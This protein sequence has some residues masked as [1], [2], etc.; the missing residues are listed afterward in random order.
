MFTF[1]TVI[2]SIQNVKKQM[3]NTFVTDT[4]FKDELNQLVDSQTE[5]AK[6]SVKSSVA[7]AEAIATQA[8]VQMATVI[9]TAFSGRAK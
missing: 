6:G 1:D 7:I 9:P 2:D 8:K 4:K 5:F 3:V